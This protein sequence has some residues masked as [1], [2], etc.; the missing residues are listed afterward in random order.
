MKASAVFQLLTYVVGEEDA[1]DVM[2]HVAVDGALLDKPVRG[3]ADRATIAQTLALVL[4]HD[5]LRRVPAAKRYVH[6]FKPMHEKLVL[7]H[8][9]VRT[10]KLQG[11]GALPCGEAAVTRLL[12]P[13][14]YAFAAEYPLPALRMT[15]RSY[16]HMDFPE[17]IP[18]F[19]V[20]EILPELFSAPFQTAVANTFASSHDPVSEKL[21]SQLDALESRGVLEFHDA[22]DVVLRVARCFDRQHELPKFEDYTSLLDESAEMGWIATE[23][24][25]FNH[26]TVRVNDV[27]ALHASLVEA[28]YAIKPEVEISSS[29]NVLQTALLADSV[30]R[31]LKGA[32]S[33]YIEHTVPGSFC[34][35]IQRKGAQGRDGVE[36][37]DLGFDSGNA[38]AIFKMTTA[39]GR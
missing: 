28:G 7:D 17:Q 6:E 4:F 35:F 39:A 31:R 33:S 12:K 30:S 18:Q 10:V 19:F 2:A 26:I 8:G 20:S 29:G 38:T 5:L 24:N 36:R 14:G 9:A 27:T 23:G 25:T 1:I 3:L 34:E 32:T 37:L 11:M 15:G 22:A 13:L 16:R 21:Q